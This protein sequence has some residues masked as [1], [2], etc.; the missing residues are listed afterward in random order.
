MVV[1]SS[2]SSKKL[3]KLHSLAI[4]S[5]VMHHQKNITWNYTRNAESQASVQIY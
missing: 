5:V 3:G 1:H 4:Q 2:I